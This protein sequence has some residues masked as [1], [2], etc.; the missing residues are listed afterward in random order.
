MLEAGLT[1]FTGNSNQALAREIC[2]YIDVPLGD[3]VIS[4]FPDSE[5]SVKVNMDV[6]G[7]DVYIVQST[8][9]PV[10]DHLMEMLVLADCLKRASAKRI[11]AVIPYFGYARQDRKDEGRTPISAKLVANLLVSAGVDRVLTIDLHAAQ[12]QGFFDIPV[13]HLY[14]RTVITSYFK[15]LD[16]ASPVV[17]S[18]DVGGI[19]LA[20]SY[21]KV[22]GAELAVVDKR[23]TSPESTETGFVIGD[24]KGKT[25]ILA[26]D[27]ISTAG[28]ICQ[29]ARVVMD[30]GAESV[31]IC[32]THPVFCGPAVE[33]LREVSA[34]GV[35]VTNTI[36]VDHPEIPKFR[37][38]SVAQLLGEAIR[39]IHHNKSVSSLF[40]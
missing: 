39:R 33:R 28:T 34:R 5:I 18:P 37:V 35:V 10:N 31:Y 4:R 3:A 8:C 21:A 16:L 1:V 23:R 29:A 36:P 20:R 12:I 7:T 15:S 38:L 24:V 13:D 26:D 25:A 27:L 14:A 19:R 6:R 40:G 9:P 30:R 2:D 32:A 17:V 22:I 11:S